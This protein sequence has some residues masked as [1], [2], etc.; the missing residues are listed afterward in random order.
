MLEQQWFDLDHFAIPSD[1]YRWLMLPGSLTAALRARTKFFSVQLISE[2]FVEIHWPGAR[3][4]ITQ[5][6][7]SRKVMLK[8]GEQPWVA[9]HTLVPQQSLDNGLAELTRLANQ[10]LGEL[11][12]A[13]PN[14]SKGLS[15]VCRS[16]QGWGRRACYYLHRQPLLVSEFFLPDLISHEHRRT[17][18]LY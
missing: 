7:F 11:L 6:C 9:A 1:Y 16:E 10:P 8:D 17:S 14:V 12:F 13:D 5:Q 3:Q 4:Q 2:Q 18:A 15:E